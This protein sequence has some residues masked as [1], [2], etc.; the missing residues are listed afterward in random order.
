MTAGQ[1]EKHYVTEKD[2]FVLSGQ[3]PLVVQWLIAIAQIVAP[4]VTGILAWNAL[5][6]ARAARENAD[7]AAREFRL[8]HLP[9]LKITRDGVFIRREQVEAVVSVQNASKVPLIVH[10][11]RTHART[12]DAPNVDGFY[13]YRENVH[14]QLDVGES[15]QIGDN[16]VVVECNTRTNAWMPICIRVSAIVSVVGMPDIK[17]R[18]AIASYIY[19]A[20][21]RGLRFETRDP[22]LTMQSPTN[23]DLL[24]KLTHLPK[25]IR[26]EL[27]G[28]WPC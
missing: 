26:E 18:W 28:G 6:T 9:F 17:Y 24:S 12:Y 16:G 7:T 1:Q 5:N 13:A 15:V 4:I 3:L 10:S 23:G 20:V 22:Q 27:G 11:L 21:D 19:T 14:L 2:E 25:K 8:A